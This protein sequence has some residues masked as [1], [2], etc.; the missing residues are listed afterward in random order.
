[1]KLTLQKAKSQNIGELCKLV[2][3]AYRGELGWTKETH[4]L[5]GERATPEE[6]QEYLSNPEVDLFIV[7]NNQKAIACIC[8][9]TKNEC[10][11]V[12]FFAVH[13]SLQGTGIGKQILAQAEEFA[14]KERKVK[15]FAMVVISQRNELIAFYERRGYIKTGDIDDYPTH[16]NV[17]KPLKSG[18]TI[19]HL[20]KKVL[21]KI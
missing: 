19:T 5:A 10:G 3:L 9:E 16:L 20:E 11:Y 21:A 14:V 6:V 2:N 1:M 12:G 18:L 4:L 8:I 15:K 7:F 17:G 13:P